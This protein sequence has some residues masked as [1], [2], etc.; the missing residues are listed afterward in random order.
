[1]FDLHIKLNLPLVIKTD[2]IGAIFMSENALTGFRTWYVD[3]RYQFIREFI[4]DG[5][6]KI[7]FVSS[8]ENDSG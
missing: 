5:F 2:Y 8:A 6:I 3:K 4:E 7:E 1:L